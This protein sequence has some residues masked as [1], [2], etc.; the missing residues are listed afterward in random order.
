MTDRLT[1]I[2][3]DMGA[4][5]SHIR[6]SLSIAM[7]LGLF[8][9]FGLSGYT[10][11]SDNL[12]AQGI[13]GRLIKGD[14]FMFFLAI[15]GLGSIKK[16]HFPLEYACY[17]LFILASGLTGLVSYVPRQASIEL[18]VHIW[19]W[20]GSLIIFNILAKHPEEG[21]PIALHL[22]LYSTT[23]LA[24]LGFLHLLFFPGM[25]PV[26]TYGGVVGTFRNAGQSGS[27]MGMVLA[28]I[29]PGMLCGMVKPSRIHSIMVAIL[30][31][32]LIFATKRAAMIG[33]GLGYIGLLFLL[34]SYGGT[35]YKKMALQLFFLTLTLFPI[36]YL[37]VEW[38]K[39]NIE[40]MAYRLDHKLGEGTLDR[41]A[42]NFFE[43]NIAS[44]FEA[45]LESP[46]IG[47]GMGNIAGVYTVKY[48]IHSTYFKIIATGGLIGVLCY[49]T[50]LGIW[51]KTVLNGINTKSREG[52]F[53]LY[54]TP[55]M[56]GLMVSW[57]YTYHLRK[58]EFWIAFA[59]VLLIARVSKIKSQF[60]RVSHHRSEAY[61]CP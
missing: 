49:G 35:K 48:E 40:T 57:I 54:F 53:L 46:I 61:N 58:R 22:L 38:G 45:F 33:L 59:I 17:L 13:L 14:I 29:I 28:I 11:T 23:I 9:Y 55:F 24:I 30:I 20:L 37:G 18:V 2:P 41:F 34:M 39:E 4:Q 3:S 43:E 36:I 8:I 31:A 10:Q 16:I 15:Y 52:L 50:F 27:Y 44:A 32:S 1:Y 47:V 6:P 21:P 51:V 5:A 60:D 26:T 25:F 7:L 42:S 12:V 19:A 56:L